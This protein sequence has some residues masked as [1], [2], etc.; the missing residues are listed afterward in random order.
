MNLETSKAYNFK[1]SLQ[2]FWTFNDKHLAED[3]LNKWYFWATHSKIEPVINAAK[4][5]KSHWTGIINYIDYRITNGILEGLNGIIQSVKRSARGFKTTTNL[6]II[7]Y[8]RLGKLQ[9]NL[10]T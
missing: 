3:Y 8:L 9:F 4:T 6:I 2:D 7:I 10:P 1:L 5:I